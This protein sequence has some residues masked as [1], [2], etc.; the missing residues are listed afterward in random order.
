MDYKQEYLNYKNKYLGLKNKQIGGMIGLNKMNL[1]NNFNSINL[2]NILPD[3]KLSDNKLLQINT[4]VN[5][6]ELI[7]E[8]KHMTSK[9]KDNDYVFENDFTYRIL[10]SSKFFCIFPLNINYDSSVI[11]LIGLVLSLN[12]LL[13]FLIVYSI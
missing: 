2:K 12:F 13:N 1:K 9:K 7:D 10:D 4:E 3:L 6:K 8:I 5:D 11:G